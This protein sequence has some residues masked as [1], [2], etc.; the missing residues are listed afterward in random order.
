[1]N[2]CPLDKN[3]DRMLT[4]KLIKPSFQCVTGTA[5]AAKNPSIGS[6]ANSLLILLAS[7]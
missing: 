3:V 6:G 2:H 4:L 1:M 7:T 5:R